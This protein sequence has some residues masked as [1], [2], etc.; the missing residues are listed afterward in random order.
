MTR[1]LYFSLL[2]AVVLSCA[3]AHRKEHAEREKQYRARLEYLRHYRGELVK[4]GERAESFVATA[5]THQV[6][7]TP[8]DR[9][10]QV[11][12]L[13]TYQKKISHQIDSVDHLLA[14]YADSLKSLVGGR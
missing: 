11:S 2:L 7:R 3:G 8:Q 4:E 1:P 12:N 6:L 13:K 5:E 10:T 14:L 9:E